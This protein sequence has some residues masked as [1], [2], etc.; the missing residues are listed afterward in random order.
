MGHSS[1]R[2]LCVMWSDL[3]LDSV[4]SPLTPAQASNL[5]SLCRHADDLRQDFD[6]KDHHIESRGLGH[7]LERE[8]QVPGQR[9]HPAR[10]ADIDLRRKTTRRRQNFVRF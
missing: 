6:R 5:D 8:G 2:S 4:L 10:S 3:S 7:H 9:R 1:I